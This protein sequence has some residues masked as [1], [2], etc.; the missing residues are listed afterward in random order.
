MRKQ[1]P[2]QSDLHEVGRDISVANLPPDLVIEDPAKYLREIRATFLRKAREARG[3]TI[4]EVATKCHIDVHDLRRIESGKV[5]EQDMA[6]LSDLATV[7]GI[8]YPSLLFLFRL[9][10]RPDRTQTYK[11]A[12]Y[13][14]QKIDKKTQEELIQFV[15]KLKDSI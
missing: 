2:S 7:Y 11:M 9:A 12:A 15:E 1:P 4:E 6:V 5:N 8:D 10:R 3:L 14:D 13:H